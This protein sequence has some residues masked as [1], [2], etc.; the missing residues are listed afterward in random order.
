MNK[1]IVEDKTIYIY[2]YSMHQICPARSRP[3]RKRNAPHG[4]GG[5]PTRG[6]NQKRDAFH[7]LED[8]RPAG[9]TDG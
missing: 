8:H 7:R 2:K 4:R 6:T 1:R 3:L 9:Y 5:K